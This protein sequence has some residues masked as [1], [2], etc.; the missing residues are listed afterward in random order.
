MIA[1]PRIR[2]PRRSNVM[3]PWILPMS[4]AER[5]SGH[6]AAATLPRTSPPRKVSGELWEQRRQRRALT[7]PRDV[8]FLNLSG[9]NPSGTSEF[10]V[11]GATYGYGKPDLDW[12]PHEF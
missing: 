4:C 3:S 12:A 8:H 1:A 7:K 11:G 9:G 10:Y 6:A 2:M 5:K